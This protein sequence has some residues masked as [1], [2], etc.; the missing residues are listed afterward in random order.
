MAEINLDHG[1]V[2][3]YFSVMYVSLFLPR[4]KSL[5]QAD[6]CAINKK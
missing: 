6:V 2:H 4:N 1:L 3:R 5:L